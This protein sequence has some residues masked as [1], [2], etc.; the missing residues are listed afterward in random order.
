[1]EGKARAAKCDVCASAAGAAWRGRRLPPSLPLSPH[2]PLH[3]LPPA[4]CPSLSKLLVNLG[5]AIYVFLI[6]FLCSKVYAFDMYEFVNLEIA[7]YMF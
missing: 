7:N 5:I 4:P 6:A 1:M 2:S 3:P